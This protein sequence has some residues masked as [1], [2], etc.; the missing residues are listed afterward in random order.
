MSLSPK[1]PSLPLSLSPRPSTAGFCEGVSMQQQST[2][3][4]GR[5]LGEGSEVM[6]S[7]SEVHFYVYA[8]HVA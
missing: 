8:E 4:E 5:R 2:R 6:G 3:R 1:P 7:P